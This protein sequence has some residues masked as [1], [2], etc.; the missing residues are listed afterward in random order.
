MSAK[1]RQSKKGKQKTRVDV[2]KK[3]RLHENERE[4][5]TDR[6]GKGGRFPCVYFGGSFENV[7]RPELRCLCG[8]RERDRDVGPPKNRIKARS[9][10]YRIAPS[11]H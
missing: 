7:K 1:Y 11:G 3:K 10:F 2:Y 5:E 6:I 8:N 4:R 9:S